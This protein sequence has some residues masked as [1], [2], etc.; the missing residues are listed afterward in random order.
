LI[1][2]QCLAKSLRNFHL[3]YP[4]LRDKKAVKMPAV[5]DF[6]QLPLWRMYTSSMTRS[7]LYVA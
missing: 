1:D 4:Y 3:S 7:K 5:L 6:V 2:I